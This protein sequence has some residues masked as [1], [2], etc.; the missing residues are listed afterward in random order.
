MKK[1]LLLLALT[2]LSVSGTATDVKTLER[3]SGDSDAAAIYRAMERFEN[4]M[5]DITHRVQ[6]VG[7]ADGRKAI[8]WHIGENNPG[9]NSVK[10]FARFWDVAD[11]VLSKDNPD[12]ITVRYENRIDSRSIGYRIKKSKNDTNTNIDLRNPDTYNRNALGADITERSMVIIQ[13][14]VFETHRTL[15]EASLAPLDKEIAKLKK[16]AGAKSSD[17]TFVNKANTGILDIAY[18][19]SSEKISGERVVIPN[20]VRQW[21]N[22]H[23]VFMDYVGADANIQLDYKRADRSVTLVDFQSKRI[24]AAKFHRNNLIIFSA[25][26]NSTPFLP[27]DWA[28]SHQ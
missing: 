26:Y 21:I 16:S 20:A 15:K 25:T 5:N 8:I 28:T 2:G 6:Y 22:L 4:D 12:Y 23:H 11:S 17:V 10:H 13:N 3:Q 9:I 24:Y 18:T 1:T 14:W 7:S 19:Q 27:S